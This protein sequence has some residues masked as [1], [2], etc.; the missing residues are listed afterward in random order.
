MSQSVGNVITGDVTPSL[1]LFL[2]A[3]DTQDTLP[4]ILGIAAPL[5]VLLLIAIVVVAIV[6]IRKKL[7]VIASHVRMRLH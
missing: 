7:Q 5:M 6:L 3:K 1:L 4:I 2:V